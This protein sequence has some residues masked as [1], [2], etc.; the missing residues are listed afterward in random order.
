MRAVAVVG[1]PSP[2]WGEEVTAVVVADEE[3]LDPDALRAHA[4]A[5][6]AA[7]KQPKRYEFVDA[8]PRNALGKVLRG[9]L[10]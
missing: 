3:R 4:A 8:L 1:R 10:R 2:E 6:P 9:E 7:Y 5:R